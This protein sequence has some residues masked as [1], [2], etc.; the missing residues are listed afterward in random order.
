MVEL[1]ASIQCLE[2]G[3]DSS[4]QVAAESRQLDLSFIHDA[5]QELLKCRQVLK[6]TY[7]FGYYL[8]G[9]ISKKQFE[10]MQVVII[11]IIVVSINYVLLHC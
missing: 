9:I 3:S 1:A 5:V 7:C 10:H 6:A 11:S 2:S 8:S 4:A